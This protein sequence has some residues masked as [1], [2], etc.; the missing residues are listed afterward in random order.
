MNLL[1][2]RTVTCPACWEP[3]VLEIDL[4]AGDQAYIEDCTVCC[5]PMR[6]RYHVEAGELV[7]LDVEP[8]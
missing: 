5:Q 7:E 1:E 3:V 8:A 2:T 4:S 6:V